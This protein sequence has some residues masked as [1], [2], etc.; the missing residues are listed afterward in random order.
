MRAKATTSKK[1]RF[2][3]STSQLTSG[4]FVKL[5]RPQTVVTGQDLIDIGIRRPAFAYGRKEF[6]VL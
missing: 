5:F 2:L 1:L 3:P 4:A 6:A